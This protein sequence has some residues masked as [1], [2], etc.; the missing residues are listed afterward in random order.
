M[1]TPSG[2]G[3]SSAELRGVPRF[4]RRLFLM[5]WAAFVAGLALA[6][7]GCMRPSAPPAIADQAS[8]SQATAKRMVE[9]GAEHGERFLAHSQTRAIRN[10]LGGARAVFLAP[11]LTDE[12]AILGIERGTGFLLR[13]H[14]KEWSDPVFAIFSETS[15]GY[16]AGVKKS[17]M[18]ILLMTDTAVDNFIRGKMELGG[19]GGFA[20]G[21]YGLGASGTGEIKGGLEM[22]MLSTNEGAFAGGGWAEVTP[23]LAMNLNDGIYGKSANVSQILAVP[24]GKYT[25]AIKLRNLLGRMVVE[26]WE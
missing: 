9:L 2:V 4:R 12:A 6:P 15:L 26:A 7:S 17:H 14:G 10:M 5:A 18:L 20:I 24:G 11:D 16:Q 23:A 3:D 22:I 21:T 13:R 8:A 1:G 25:P 19:T